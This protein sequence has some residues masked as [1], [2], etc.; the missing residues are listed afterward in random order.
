M[1][2]GMPAM[3]L[4]TLITTLDAASQHDTPLGVSDTDDNKSFR[5]LMFFMLLTIDVDYCAPLSLMLLLSA[6]R[7]TV[8]TIVH[9][10]RHLP[11]ILLAACAA[12]IDVRH[13][14]TTVIP[15]NI[16]FRATGNSVVTL[17]LRCCQ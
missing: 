12:A 10:L 3:L 17:S 11:M 9:I 14:Y 5:L 8:V 13:V 7:H 15:P 6:T 4:A 1:R 2:Q 16:L